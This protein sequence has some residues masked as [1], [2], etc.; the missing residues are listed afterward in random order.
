MPRLENWSVVVRPKD[1]YQAPELWAT[2]LAG[3]VYGH[4]KP[5]V[6]PDGSEINTSLVVS[7]KGREVKTYSGSVYTLGKVDE[8]YV[9]WCEENGAATRERLEG[10]EPVKF[11]GE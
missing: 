7:V 2:I 6:F 5:D 9:K 3:N 10:P 11:K 4:S 8:N 1:P